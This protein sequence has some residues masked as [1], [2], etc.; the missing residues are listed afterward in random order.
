MI[1]IFFYY[2]HRSSEHTP[3]AIKIP[4]VIAPLP[5]E[6]HG[7]SLPLIAI[8]QQSQ[9]ENVPPQTAKFPKVKMNDDLLEKFLAAFYL[10]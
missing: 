9:V 8:K 10:S 1:S 7:S 2:Y 4:P 3:L 6:F 5:I